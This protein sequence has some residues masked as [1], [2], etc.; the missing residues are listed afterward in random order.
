MSKGV[1]GRFVKCPA[2]VRLVNYVDCGV[3]LA[4]VLWGWKDF[5]YFFVEHPNIMGNCA[6]IPLAEK[7][8][9]RWLGIGDA[10]SKLLR[11]CFHIACLFLYTL[12][13][14]WCAVLEP[15]AVKKIVEPLA[16]IVPLPSSK[17]ESLQ[18]LEDELWP[19]HLRTFIGLGQLAIPCKVKVSYLFNFASQETPEPS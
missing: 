11:Q 6:C 9:D 1:S 5:W 8:Q 14:K 17:L 7:P 19:K 18:G 4:M 3:K 10:L 15:R 16:R 13:V 2:E 12:K